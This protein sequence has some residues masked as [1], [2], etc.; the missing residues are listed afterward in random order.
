M[1]ETQNPLLV[2]ITGIERDENFIEGD[3]I[4][5]QR[6]PRPHRPR[7]IILVADYEL[8]SH[9]EK[10]LLLIFHPAIARRKGSTPWCRLPRWNMH[11]SIHGKRG[12]AAAWVRIRSIS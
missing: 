11:G 1:R 12:D 9:F 7:G 8:Q 6:Q 10:S 3:V 4:V 2:G 5:S